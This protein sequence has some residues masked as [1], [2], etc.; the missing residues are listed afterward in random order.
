MFVQ[1]ITGKT[2]DA[3]GVRAQS[4][5]WAEELKPGATGFLGGTA[6]VADDGTL[7]VLACFEDEAAA[8]ANS[9]RP[10]QGEWWAGMEALLDGEATF[11]SSSDTSPLFDGPNQSAG[12]VQIMEG[13]V[14]DRAKAEAIETPELEAQ[15]K[16]ARPDLLGGLRVW[17]DGGAYIEAAYFTSEEEARK[18][19]T[20]ADFEQPQEEYAAMF[21]DVTYTDL[22]DP[23]FT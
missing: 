5:R 3:A 14:P 2:K 22:R 13:V 7:I 4:E 23:I 11:R 18:G 19:E 17:F 10:E 15:L 9:D 1:V 8:Q 16:Q 12:F 21:G 20:N 6:G